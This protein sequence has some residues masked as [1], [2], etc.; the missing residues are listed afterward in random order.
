MNRRNLIELG[1]VSALA[2]TLSE[3]ANAAKP[4][5]C[6]LGS[7]AAVLGV[8][9]GGVRVSGPDAE[10]FCLPHSSAVAVNAV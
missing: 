2:T 3:S 5:K 8:R 6:S 10:N 9:P 4:S 1:A 7:A